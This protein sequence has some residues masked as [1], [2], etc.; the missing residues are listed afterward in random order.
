MLGYNRRW[1]SSMWSI[2]IFKRISVLNEMYVNKIPFKYSII[3]FKKLFFFNPTSKKSSAFYKQGSLVSPDG[4]FAADR[5]S[6]ITSASCSFIPLRSHIGGRRGLSGP[7]ICLESHD[8]HLASFIVV[9]LGLLC[10]FPSA[11]DS[12]H[13]THLRQIL[14]TCWRLWPSNNRVLH[15]AK[16]LH[17]EAMIHMARAYGSCV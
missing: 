5:Q 3:I 14:G 2:Y 13:Q 15:G 11:L 9:K 12:C 4:E 16:S 10:R 17:L 8:T 6:K 7:P 1:P